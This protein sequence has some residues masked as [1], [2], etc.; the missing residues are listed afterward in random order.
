VKYISEDKFLSSQIV[1]IYYNGS[2]DFEL[3]PRVGAHQIIFG[4]IKDYQLKFM[5]LKVLYEEGLKYEGWNKYVMINL[6][7]KNQVIC[8]KR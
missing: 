3:I 5:K 7:Y 4:D 2:G 1:Q 6:K 8:T